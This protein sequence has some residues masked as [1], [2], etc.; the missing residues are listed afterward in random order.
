[1]L[2]F[3]TII[4]IINIKNPNNTRTISKSK[5]ENGTTEEM[6]DRGMANTGYIFTAYHSAISGKRLMPY[7][8]RNNINATTNNFITLLSF[9]IQN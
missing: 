7:I 9:I 3:L 1:M 2:I 6:N 8:K 4:K 5:I